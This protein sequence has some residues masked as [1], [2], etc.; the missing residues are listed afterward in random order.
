VEPRLVKAS[1]I[2]FSV[3]EELKVTFSSSE[4]IGENKS[5]ISFSIAGLEEV[6]RLEKWEIKLPPTSSLEDTQTPDSSFRKFTA[7]ALLLI[8]VDK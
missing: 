7:L 5:R 2:Y 4:M 6:K 8:R 3:G 1:R